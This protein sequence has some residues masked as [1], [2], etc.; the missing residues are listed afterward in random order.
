MKNNEKIAI[1]VSIISIILNCLLT[2]IKFISGV[3]SKSSAMISDSVHSLSDVLS[4]FVVI[5]GVKISNKKADSDHP[6][7]HERIECVSAIILSG[8]LF[9]VGA[10]IGING[11]KNVTNSSNLVMPGVLALIAS[12]IS[13]I[14]KEAM[15]QYTIRVSKKINSAALKADAWHHR[16]DALSSIGS[17]IGILGSRLGFK[18]FDPLASVIISLCIIKV[19]IDIFKDAIDKMVDKSCDKE[20]ID[21]VISVIEKNESVKNIDDIKT[22][23]FGNKAYVDVE[24][25]V[26]ENL[27]LKDAHKVAEEIHDSVENEINIVKHCMVHVNPYEVK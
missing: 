9:V 3:I 23:Q 13:I 26:D 8:M 19:S 2:L 27:L 4:T 16:S 15:Y 11:I 21:K 17:F 1:K 25:S 24:I 12:I 20:V 14:S 6:Y 5:I 7:G 10:L 22:R 18:V